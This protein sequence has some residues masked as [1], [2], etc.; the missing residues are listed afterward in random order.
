M[1]EEVLISH[2][3]PTLAGLKT[4]NMITLKYP[5]PDE[6]DQDLNS[7]NLRLRNKGVRMIPLRWQDG[8]GLIY[9]Y[10]PD[11]LCR[12][13][14]DSCARKIMQENG[15]PVD[16]PDACLNCLKDRLSSCDH[17]PHEIGLFLGYPS[18]DV[19]GFIDNKAQN[20]KY[21]GCWKVYGN[22]EKAMILFSRFQKCTNVYREKWGE[23]RSLEDLTVRSFE[24]RNFV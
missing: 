18:E 17:F 6:M 23:G 24:K 10:R 15:Y 13:L 22:L 2:C 9:I 1:P 21:T 16:D 7:M 5:D 3:A 19:L 20:S 4:A 11:K 8:I 14:Q 12:D